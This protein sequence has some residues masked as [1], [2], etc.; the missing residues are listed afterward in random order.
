MLGL[1]RVCLG[2]SRLQDLTMSFENLLSA[3]DEAGFA[4]LILEACAI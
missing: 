3:T 2:V 4:G 1:Q